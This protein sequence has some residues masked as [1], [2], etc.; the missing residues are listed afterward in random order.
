[1][2]AILE[3]ILTQMETNLA[4]IEDENFESVII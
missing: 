3:F 2:L 1:M 4:A